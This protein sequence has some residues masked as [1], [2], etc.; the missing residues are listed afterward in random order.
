MTVENLTACNF[1]E[2]AG[3]A[4]NEI[5]FNFGDGSGKSVRG[6][7]QGNYLNATSTFY[8]TG[9]PAASYGIF[10]SNSRGPGTFAHTYA[11]NMDD[12]SYY[13]GACTD[14]N[15]VLTDGHAQY[16]VLGYSGTNAGGHLRD[17]ELGV[18]PQ[19]VWDR[20]QQPEQR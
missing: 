8:A 2:G 19:P 14:C 10:S 17:R 9:K 6:A 3:S 5:W 16:S 15:Q 18:G 12:S 20:H 7:F 1:L 11:S 4:G 13:I